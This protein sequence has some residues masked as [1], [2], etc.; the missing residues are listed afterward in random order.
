[1][2]PSRLMALAVAAEWEQQV[3]RLSCWTTSVYPFGCRFFH[4]ASLWCI[5]FSWMSSAWSD[6]VSHGAAACPQETGIKPFTMP[7]MT[8]AATAIDQ[9][10]AEQFA[11]ERLRI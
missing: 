8:L 5:T 2:L 6:I 7:L 3:F 10:S 1:M 4:I 11:L 9:V